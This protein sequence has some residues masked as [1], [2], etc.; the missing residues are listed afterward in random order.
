MGLRKKRD[1]GKTFV[2]IMLG[3]VVML[4]GCGEPLS[5]NEELSPEALGSASQA[6][7]ANPYIYPGGVVNANNY[8]NVIHAGDYISVFG[9]DLAT[10]ATTCG[11]GME[12]CGCTRIN[13]HGYLALITY[14][15][16]GQV[17]AI[18]PWTLPPG[19]HQMILG[20]DGRVSNPYTLYLY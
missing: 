5:P 17:N 16:P 7:T 4:S 3:A 9:T 20:C 15:S 18:V 6:V 10:T 14:A 1:T 11:S 19:N 12:Q 13:I 2:S 8:S